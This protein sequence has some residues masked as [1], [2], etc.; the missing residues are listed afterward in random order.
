MPTGTL[1]FETSLFG[2]MN[3]ASYGGPGDS[4]SSLPVNA[5]STI[6]LRDSTYPSTLADVLIL[7]PSE[8]NPYRKKRIPR[9]GYEASLNVYGASSNAYSVNAYIHKLTAHI[10]AQELKNGAIPTTVQADAKYPYLS[11]F[12]G[13]TGGYA[14]TTL[15]GKYVTASE[16]AR[17]IVENG[18]MLY[19]YDSSAS[20]VIHTTAAA[21]K[22]YITFSYE[23]VTLSFR[24][25][26]P[27]GF[28]NRNASIDFSWEIN[29]STTE[30]LDLVEAESVV[31]Q[32]KDGTDGTVHEISLGKASGYQ[33]PAGTLP[34][35]DSI[36][37]QIKAT[38]ND[39]L[40]FESGWKTL[41][42]SD[43]VPTVSPISPSGE[44]VGAGDVVTFKWSYSIPSG[45]KQTAFEIQTKSGS[46]SFATILTGEGEATEATVP[47]SSLPSGEVSWRVRAANSEGVY[48]E[49]SAAQTFMVVSPPAQPFL[50]V[51]N[52]T[53][54][55]EVSWQ[56]EEQ[57]GYEVQIGSYST[58]V[59]YGTEKQAKSKIYLPDGETVARVR[60][61]NEFGLW[62][63]WAEVDFTI[64]NNPIASSVVLDVSGGVDARL[65]WSAVAAA[66]G[67]QIFRN[68]EKI[69]D[70]KE[71]KYTDRLSIG[72]NEYYIKAYAGNYYV[73]SNKETAEVFTEHPVISALDGE[74]LHMP[75]AA[76]SQREIKMQHSREA[77][78]VRY[79]GFRY[80]MPEFTPYRTRTYTISVAFA[81]RI[82][83]DAFEALLDGLVVV[84]DQY[85]NC[86]VGVMN[87]F[88]KAQNEFR[89]TYTAT[90]NEV[91]KAAYEND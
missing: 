26:A 3:A 83:C 43:Y 42:T 91:D 31:L 50:T 15:E 57:Q 74:W 56:S 68:G 45:T 19:C 54:R 52:T 65:S 67:Y 41:R 80:Q 33:M 16:D 90:V 18:C 62:S 2:T 1:Y 59:V 24:N 51:T 21:N 17:Q 13:T 73:D 58:G 20:A 84:K 46:A 8:N 63:E 47:V 38:S 4:W 61:I 64:V 55:P 35:S 76:T 27:T 25:M 78:L 37:W 70:T 23:D 9:Q 11:Y 88:S 29:P 60:V 30:T 72:E 81:D 5:G 39:N 79:A 22:P 71:T 48:S 49:W 7:L 28:V 40:T 69:A 53:A 34:V 86:M 75:L 87:A 10:T 32:W 89:T 14:L 82:S 85:G 6:T 36:L 66:E 77:S 44:Y 12:N